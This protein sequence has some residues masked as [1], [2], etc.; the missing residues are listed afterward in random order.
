[1]NK[2][3]LII[4]ILRNLVLIESLVLPCLYMHYLLQLVKIRNLHVLTQNASMA[5]CD[6]TIKMIAVITAMKTIV[7]CILVLSLKAKFKFAF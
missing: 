2:K 7:V 5:A 3:D 1:M 6:V 4:A